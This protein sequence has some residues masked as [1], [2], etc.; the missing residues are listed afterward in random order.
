MASTDLQQ[1]GT[2]EA[3]VRA[4]FEAWIS[5]PPYEQSVHRWPEDGS[6]AWP[7]HYSTY[8]VQL[9]FEAW[10]AARGETK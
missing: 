4:E 6:K 3:K 7:G 2:K 5:A 8:M 10:C 9:A 1:K